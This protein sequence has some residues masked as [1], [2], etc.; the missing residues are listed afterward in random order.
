MLITVATHGTDDLWRFP[1]RVT[2]VMSNQVQSVVQSLIPAGGIEAFWP[3]VVLS[4]ATGSRHEVDA[5]GAGPGMYFAA[6]TIVALARAG[7]PCF[8]GLCIPGGVDWKVFLPRLQLKLIKRARA[9]VLIVGDRGYRWALTMG[10]HHGAGHGGG[11][12]VMR[13]HW[14]ESVSAAF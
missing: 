3:M 14:L 10:T 5:Q 2:T 6:A 13:A 4:Y 7:F 8:S 12:R 9:M 11:G 1:G